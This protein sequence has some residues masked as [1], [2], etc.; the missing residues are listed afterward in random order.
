MPA[1]TFS[2][3]LGTL[4]M[5]IG[6]D[7]NNWGDLA[8]ASIFQIFEDAIANVLPGATGNVAGGTL[9][10][11]ASP[12]PAGPSQARYMHLRFTGALGS[13]QTIVVPNKSKL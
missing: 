7:N 1:D 11:S 3:T 8:N 2:S 10:L 4:V 12:P 9:D 13:N 5:G 6:N